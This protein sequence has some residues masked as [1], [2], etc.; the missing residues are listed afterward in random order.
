M[1]SRQ[2]HAKTRELYGKS[3]QSITSK[4]AV[5]SLFKQWMSFEEENGT[6]DTIDFVKHQ[7]SEVMATD[8]MEIE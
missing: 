2:D 3:T 7:L 5:S 8:D 1:K 6:P 4:K